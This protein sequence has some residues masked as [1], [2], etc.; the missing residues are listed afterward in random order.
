MIW[1]RKG[2]FWLKLYSP[3]SNEARKGTQGRR[4]SEA[5]TEVQTMEEHCSPWFAQIA[6]VYHSVTPAQGWHCSQWAE[7]YHINY[8]L[9]LQPF[10][11]TAL[12]NHPPISGLL[13][14]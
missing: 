3:S 14:P 11:W 4:N 12:S 10:L 2:S 6:P 7:S 9:F 1:G 13:T 5:G 8:A